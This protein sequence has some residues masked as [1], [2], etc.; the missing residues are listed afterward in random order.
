[1]CCNFNKRLWSFRCNQPWGL[2]FIYDVGRLC[3]SSTLVVVAKFTLAEPIWSFG[4]TSQWLCSPLQSASK[5][6]IEIFSRGLHVLLPLLAFGYMFF[7]VIDP[8]AMNIGP[9]LPLHCPFLKSSTIILELCNH[10]GLS[11]ILRMEVGKMY[12]VIT[13]SPWALRQSW[14]SSCL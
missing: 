4:L 2:C 10:K 1:M 11:F 9:T 5:L 8:M 3:L 14:Y 13:D 12:L 7:H 6:D